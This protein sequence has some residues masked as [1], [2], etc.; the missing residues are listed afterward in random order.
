M[1]LSVP[2]H[3]NFHQFDQIKVAHYQILQTFIKSVEIKVARY[4]AQKEYWNCKNIGFDKI[5]VEIKVARYQI[6]G[7]LGDMEQ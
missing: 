6:G 2:R 1:A 3:L 7:N 5:L 4:Q